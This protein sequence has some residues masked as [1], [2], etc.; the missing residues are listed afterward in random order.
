[1]ADLK[2]EVAIQEI[3]IMQVTK[4]RD[5]LQSKAKDFILKF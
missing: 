2:E 3:R 1:V 4:D 5:N